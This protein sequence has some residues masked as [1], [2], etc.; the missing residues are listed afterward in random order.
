MAMTPQEYEKLTQQYSPNTK[1]WKTIPR[2]WLF[3]GGICCIG[4]ALGDLYRYFGAQ[5]ELVPAL[6]SVSLIVLAALL[7]GFGVFDDIASVGGA[8]CLVPITG[9]SNAVTAPALEFKSEGLVLGLGAKMF[10]IAGP[11]IVYG[12]TA[13]AVYGLI[14]WG[15]SG[16]KAVF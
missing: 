9:F 15:I 12:V 6:I 13:S 14:Y 3:G 2:A 11:G 16:C 5:E 4:Q 10:V 8:G 7:T 1:S